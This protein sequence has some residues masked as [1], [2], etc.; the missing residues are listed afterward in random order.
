MLHGLGVHHRIRIFFHVSG[1][2]GCGGAGLERRAAP[3]CVPRLQDFVVLPAS[4]RFLPFHRDKIAWAFRE[5]RVGYAGPFRGDRPSA[6]IHG[7]GARRRVLRNRWPIFAGDQADNR[8]SGKLLH[9]EP[10]DL[11][12]HVVRHRGI[13]RLHGE[14]AL[15]L[16]TGELGIPGAGFQGG[17][18][19]SP[20]ILQC[21]HFLAQRGRFQR[22]PSAP[23]AE[24]GIDNMVSVLQRIDSRTGALRQQHLG[25]G[26][27]MISRA[28][29]FVVLRPGIHV[30]GQPDAV[31]GTPRMFIEKTKVPQNRICSGCRGFALRIAPNRAQ[32]RRQKAFCPA[33]RGY[34]PGSRSAAVR[35]PV[36]ELALVF[37]DAIH[38]MGL[39]VFQRPGHSGQAQRGLQSQD[40]PGGNKIGQAQVRR[41]IVH[42]PFIGHRQRQGREIVPAR[43]Q[44]PEFLT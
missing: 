14:L 11:S 3:R 40:V 16:R 12:G 29:L 19:A 4:A 13:V 30:M 6:F 31:R 25:H 22:N 33:G 8:I 32:R 26:E 24:R 10:P 38:D 15:L 23:G 7:N 37:R 35:P 34:F 5:Q 2:R 28:G 27:G 36:G 17:N 1:A 42:T 20:R 9:P 43:F 41:V 21:G 39:Y 18:S 44:L